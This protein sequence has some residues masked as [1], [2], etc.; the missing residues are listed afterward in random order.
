[1]SFQ[2]FGKPEY[3]STACLLCGRC[4]AMKQHLE[5]QRGKSKTFCVQVNFLKSMG[6]RQTLISEPLIRMYVC[7]LCGFGYLPSV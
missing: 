7:G 3:E 1:M 2:F 6:P 4:C 5:A